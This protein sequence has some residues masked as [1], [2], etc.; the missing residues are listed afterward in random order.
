LLLAPYAIDDKAT[1]ILLVD[2]VIYSE[3]FVCGKFDQAYFLAEI[4]VDA[5]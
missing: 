2:E 1:I 3:V 4:K 5:T